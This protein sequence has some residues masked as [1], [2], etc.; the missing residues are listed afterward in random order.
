MAITVNNTQ[1]LT[2]LNGLNRTSLDQT[3]TMTRMAT[4]N[5]INAGKD[6]PAGLIALRTL[7]A[8]YSAVTQAIDNNQ[9]TNAMLDVADGAL[10]EVEGLLTDIESLIAASVGD[11]ISASEK[12]ANQAQID[13]AISSI[14]R[15]IRT[16]NFAGKSLLNGE[17][18]IQASESTGKAEDIRIY[19]RKSGT[20]SQSLSVSVTT[21]SSSAALSTTNSSTGA[22]T[23]TVTGKLGSAT[24]EISDTDNLAAEVVKINAVKEQTGVSATAGSGNGIN[25]SSV[26]TGS[27]QFVSIDMVSGGGSAGWVDTHVQN[28]ADADVTV[29]GV[30][31]AADGNKISFNINGASG[32]F[33]LTSSGDVAGTSMTIS[34]AGGGATFQLGADS[35]T[36]ETLGVASMFAHTLGKTGTG[37]LNE[38]K[39]GGSN[40]LQQ[41]GS[42]AMSII[43]EAIKDVAEARGRVGGFQKYQV[44]TSINSLQA[45][46]KGLAD[47]RGVINDVDYAEET[48]ELNRQNVLMTAGLQLLGVANQQAGQVLSL[49]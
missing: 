16:T 36:R 47:A 39:S 9:R 18:A 3:A 11:Q 27:D 21:A 8:E 15:I 12:A 22:A 28:G 44:Q 29:G 38:V 17:L 34:I 49:L 2:L 26:E 23:Y 4:G 40:A 30:S 35:S 1:T 31:A 13:Q 42:Q 48:A 45:T 37:F 43:K 7:D 25:F 6:D 5:K 20:S 24:V 19:S 14:D 32:T 10:K 46:Q 33:T 41:S